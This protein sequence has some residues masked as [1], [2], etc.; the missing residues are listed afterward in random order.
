MIDSDKHVGDVSE[1]QEKW[2]GVIPAAKERVETGRMLANV[3]FFC[4]E[5]ARIQVAALYD[6]GVS[7]AYGTQLLTLSTCNY[8]TKNGRFV[9]VAAES[10]SPD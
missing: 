7:A 3:R 1:Q 10:G 2:N 6:T 8:H 9:V 5:M 4:G